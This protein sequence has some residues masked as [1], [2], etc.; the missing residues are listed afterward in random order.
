[1]HEITVRADGYVPQLQLIAV[2]SREPAAVNFRLE[3]GGAALKLSGQ[4]DGSAVSLDGERIGRLPVDFELPPG[5]HR[6]RFESEHFQPEERDVELMLGETKRITDVS[7]R[8]LLGRATLDVRTPGT[9]VAL[10]SGTERKE[11][12][13]VGQPVELDLSRKWILEAKKDGYQT[14]REPLDWSGGLEKTFVVALDRASI[15]SPSAHVR[16][17][18]PAPGAA[19][20]PAPA[21]PAPAHASGNTPDALRA[22]MER[23][24]QRDT[25]SAPTSATDMSGPETP[26][27]VSNDPCRVSFNSIPV[28]NVFID[29]V[30]I[31]VTPILKATVRPGAHV[32][33]FVAG[34]TK[35]AKSFFC[36]PGEL[37][38][39]AISLNR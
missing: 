27:P 7:L 25:G 9:E 32:V 17:A 37:K 18:A 28:S 30:R 38:V 19:P 21:A 36:K 2:R 10:V 16:H 26:P 6:L 4:P 8:P 20:A 11:H 23:A 14:L 39:V 1:V 24:I 31:G 15:A 29:N 35:K 12:L 33:Q 13:D 5:T 34:D 22:A 3:R